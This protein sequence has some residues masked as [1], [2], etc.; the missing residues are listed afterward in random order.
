MAR[1]GTPTVGSLAETGHDPRSVGSGLLSWMFTVSVGYHEVRGY[2]VYIPR[3]VVEALEIHSDKT[4]NPKPIAFM[5]K[6]KKVEV[7][8]S[9]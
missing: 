5:I 7:R 2:Q 1:G 8:S 9:E 3:P 4:K 6:G